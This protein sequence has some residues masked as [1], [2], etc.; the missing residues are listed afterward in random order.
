LK[1]KL[2][3]EG[4]VLESNIDLEKISQ[5]LEHSS[6]R[7]L[8]RVVQKAVFSMLKRKNPALGQIDSSLRPLDLSLHRIQE[9]MITDQ[10][11]ASSVTEV[12]GEIEI[13]QGGMWLQWVKKFRVKIFN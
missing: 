8:D 1:S 4:F 11:L 2:I 12:L 6:G 10:D 5:L 7:D 9:D 13:R 3:G